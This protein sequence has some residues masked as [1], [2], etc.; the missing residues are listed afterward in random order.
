M[1]SI[2]TETY[3]DI[4]SPQ[5]K[6]RQCIRENST[7]KYTFDPTQLLPGLRQQNQHPSSP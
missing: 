5:W 7:E 4:V 6:F 2:D 1:M 3:W